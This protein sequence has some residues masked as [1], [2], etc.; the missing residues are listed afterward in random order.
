ML[1]KSLMHVKFLTVERG[2]AKVLDKLDTFLF[3]LFDY[4]MKFRTSM[5]SLRPILKCRCLLFVLTANK[6]NMC[7]HHQF[8]VDDTVVN[9][10]REIVSR[11]LAWILGYYC[12]FC[13]RKYCA[14]FKRDCE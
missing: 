12:A 11:L 6:K 3:Y 9:I 13:N 8:K 5:F 2:I 10:E 1:V 7:S 14:T 4:M